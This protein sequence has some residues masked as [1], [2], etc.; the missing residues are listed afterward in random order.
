M[1]IHKNYRKFC[2]T[3]KS[4]QN[5]IQDEHKKR[6]DLTSQIDI[7]CVTNFINRHKICD[8]IYS[9]NFRQKFYDTFNTK[10]VII[11]LLS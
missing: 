5:F 7:Q 1:A 4:S 9:H 3:F 11:F 6:K 2:D 8:T 10:N